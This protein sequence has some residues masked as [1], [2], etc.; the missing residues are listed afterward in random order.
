MELEQRVAISGWSTDDRLNEYEYSF[1]LKTDPNISVE[2]QKN[3]LNAVLVSL[4]EYS[5]DCLDERDGYSKA[6]GEPFADPFEIFGMEI[7]CKLPKTKKRRVRKN[8]E[9]RTNFNP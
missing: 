5:K 4:V 6:V 9:Q 8:E 2:L 1:E 7:P 3:I